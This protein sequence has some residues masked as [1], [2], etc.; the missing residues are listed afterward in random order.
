MAAR[1]GAPVGREA[2]DFGGT[3]ADPGS[4]TRVAVRL[5]AA[6]WWCRR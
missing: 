4:L 5:E 1:A 3:G 6:S 2:E